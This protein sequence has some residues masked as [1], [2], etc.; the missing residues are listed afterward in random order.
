MNSRNWSFIPVKLSVPGPW[1]Q[2]VNIT[3]DLTEVDMDLATFFR[4]CPG[5]DKKIIFWKKVW[6]G[7]EPL[8]SRFPN[9]FVLERQKCYHSGTYSDCEQGSD[10]NAA[11]FSFNFGAK[12][13]IN[14]SVRVDGKRQSCR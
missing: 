3:K 4:G 11:V 10:L 13:Q 7:D 1:K 14:A 5:Q 12:S 8:C 9:L 2:V 6:L